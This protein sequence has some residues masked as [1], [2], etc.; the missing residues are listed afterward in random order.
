M[1]LTQVAKMELPTLDSPSVESFAAKIS[2]TLNTTTPPPSQ[3]LSFGS[4]LPELIPRMNSP[5]LS[6]VKR[7]MAGFPTSVNLVIR[8]W[9]P[10]NRNRYRLQTRNPRP[11][12]LT[13]RGA[14]PWGDNEVR[15]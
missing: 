5:V 15:F 6:S 7:G 8:N 10:N 4:T 14:V 13:H 1:P 9:R 2:F 3:V 11:R 12:A